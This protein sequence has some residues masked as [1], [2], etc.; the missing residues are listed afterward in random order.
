M[1]D[2][3]S[4]RI[5][6]ET[7]ETQM[8]VLKESRFHPAKTITDP[9][10]ILE[11]NNV[12]ICTAGNISNIQG[13]AKS[14]KSS[15]MG[16]A[17]AAVLRNLLGK[18]ECPQE[19][20]GF[21]SKLPANDN[22]QH[23]VILHFDTEQSPYHH[24]KLCMDV[25]ARTGI[26]KDEFEMIPFHSYSLIPTD[27]AMRRKMIEQLVAE[28]DGEEQKL[29]C[30]FLDG[31]ADII[32]DPNNAEESFDVVDW[33]H[34]IS[35][36]HQC[37]VITILHENPGDSGKA[38]GHL[39][40]QI[41]R[42]SET[43]L[44][45]RKGSKAS[46]ESGKHG[47]NHVSSI[48]VECARGAQIP[49]S[50]GVSIS[51]CSEKERHTIH[52]PAKRVKETDQKKTPPAAPR[53]SALTRKQEATKKWLENTALKKPKIHK[54]LV[55]LV[56]AREKC[57]ERTA[58]ERIN[59]WVA[60]AWIHKQPGAASAP[61]ALGPLPPE[62]PETH[63]PESAQLPRSPK[64][65]QPTNNSGEAAKN[66]KRQLRKERPKPGSPVRD[67]RSANWLDLF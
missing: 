38:R 3:K 28:F 54:E 11:L 44:R 58:K 14:A 23:K 30:L 31:V 10:P 9:V 32:S 36:K 16:A 13:P 34:R 42:K 63:E 15:V 60:C 19:T 59:S 37:A 52:D 12:A 51:W 40:S 46:R 49:E 27:H 41:I 20:L 29:A 50:D 57:K 67:R 21:S 25:I 22:K 6:Q 45:V 18:P 48:W 66:G 5:R 61:Y 55:V 33:L 2:G 8:R 24:H 35:A 53:S 47:N 64:N 39:G 4:E 7:F 26:G 1:A 17:I 43:N 62:I 65:R 56:M